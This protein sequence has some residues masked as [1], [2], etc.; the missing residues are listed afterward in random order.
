MDA[1]AVK[2]HVRTIALVHAR[3]NARLHVRELRKALHV[4]I[5]LMIV[6]VHVKK[7]ARK[8]ARMVAKMDVKTD[9]RPLALL[10]VKAQQRAIRLQEQSAVI[11][12]LI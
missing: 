6:L 4:L 11:N 12:M 1:T 7:A 2:P 5:V 10:L 9:V 8:V 3:Q